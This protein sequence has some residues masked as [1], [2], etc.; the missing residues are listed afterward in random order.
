MGRIG[1]N[2]ALYGGD[3]NDYIAPGTGSD[4]IN[5]GAGYDRVDYSN[6][7]TGVNIT[8]SL[9]TS[10]EGVVGTKY[11]DTLN[12][13]SL[14]ITN[15]DNLVT[16]LISIKGNDGND[17]ITGSQ[18]SD[19]LDGGAGSDNMI[20]GLG[21][22]VY[23][24]DS[25]TDT[26]TENANEGTDRIE[27]S[28]TFSLAAL[29]NIENLT[30]T[31]TAAINGTGNAGNNIITG[32]AGNNTLSGGAGDDIYIIDS[33][34]DT[35]V[36]NTNEGT[37]TIQSSV[38]FSIANLSNIE[39]LTLTGTAAINGTGNAGNNVITGNAGNNI[40]D[41]GAGIDSLIGGAGNDVLNPGYNQGATDTV[42]GGSDTDT[43]QV[44]YSSK[45]D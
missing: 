16:G 24:V 18:Y 2:D 6:L 30:L 12:F 33:T 40:L 37:D 19:L 39:N 41:G 7:T 13:S 36:E 28:I 21:N 20:G 32:N 3:G 25:A 10:I 45:T 27:S 29:P 15:S 1:R 31:G 8:S 14:T 35:I 4:T 44:D 23:I 5:G 43:L 17:T 38:T 11:N 26:I 22:D 34:S 9:F 42:D